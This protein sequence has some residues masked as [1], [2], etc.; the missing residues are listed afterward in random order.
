MCAGKVKDYCCQRSYCRCIMWKIAKFIVFN[1]LSNLVQDF[2]SNDSGWGNIL[3]PFWISSKGVGIVVDRDVPLHASLNENQNGK[4]ELK[5]DFNMSKYK[6]TNN[7]YPVLKYDICIAK[8]I[9]DLW[10]AMYPLH[11]EKPRAIP[12][13]RMFSSPIWSTWAKYKVHVNEQKVLAYANEIQKYGFPNSQLEIDDMYTSS[14]GEM[15]FD[16]KK[17]PNAKAMMD[18]LHKM[19]FRVTSWTHPFVNQESPVFKEG[20]NN[21]NRIYIA[22]LIQIL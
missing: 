14:Y 9:K 13:D 12:D 3:E 7:S 6:N 16:A 11:Y 19:G 15:D 5:A 22:Q 1:F 21:N 4:M 2:F 10:L 17:F 8:N 20:N 18:K